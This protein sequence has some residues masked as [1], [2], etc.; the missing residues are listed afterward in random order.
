MR[1]VR[2]VGAVAGVVFGTGVSTVLFSRERATGVHRW[3]TTCCSLGDRPDAWH[4]AVLGR[5]RSSVAGVYAM[6]KGCGSSEALKS[7]R[8]LGSG[9]A[10]GNNGFI[11][12]CAHIFD[13]E[14]AEEGHVVALRFGDGRICLAEFWAM[15]RP[16]DVAV[17]RLRERVSSFDMSVGRMQQGDWV[18]VCGTPQH[19][20]ELIGVVGVVS[21]PRQEFHEMALDSWVHF[22]QL[23]VTTLPGMS[24]SPVLNSRGEVVGMLEKKFEEHGLA[25]P[26]SHVA[27]VA[28][29]LE[30]HRAWI[31]PVLG[32]VLDGAGPLGEPPH[33][34]VQSVARGGAGASAGVRRDDEL[35]AIDGTAVFSLVDVRA[36]LGVLASAAFLATKPAEVAVPLRLRRDGKEFDVVLSAPC[37]R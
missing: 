33:L 23:A 37:R 1:V 28:R 31:P 35:I 22:A 25:L 8:F 5:A 36:A 20:K 29:C 34:V 3:R 16:A 27:S 13:E 18:V 19:A 15:S 11:L 32:F 12:T 17:L 9:F 24:G 2:P 21:Q 26:V 7:A 14:Q 4:V 6:N 10:Y 30:L